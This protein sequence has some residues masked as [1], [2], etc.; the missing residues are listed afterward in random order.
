MLRNER[1][2]LCAA[3]DTPRFADASVR[4]IIHL[5]ERHCVCA[6][7]WAPLGF[8]SA[9]LPRL[10]HPANRKPQQPMSTSPPTF[11]LTGYGIT[12]TTVHHNL[13][14]SDEHTFRVNRQRVL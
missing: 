3:A 13:P 5:V 2:P 11:D 1:R 10:I 7:S 12:V 8:W 14:S 9:A 6:V 4:G